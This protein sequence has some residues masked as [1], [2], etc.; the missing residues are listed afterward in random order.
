MERSAAH[1]FA[2]LVA[3]AASSSAHVTL[4]PNFGAAAGSYFFTS[5]KVPHGT[6]DLET[7]KLTVHIPHGLSTAVPEAKP[8]WVATTTLRSI[9]PYVSHGAT[10]DTAPATI[11][12]TA[13]CEGD[14]A[15][16]TCDNADHAGLHN[17]HLLEFSIQTKLG[18]DFG[19][20]QITGEATDDATIW[21]GEHALWFR[22]EQFLSTPGTN[23]GNIDSKGDML[24]W[25]G[26][27][28]GDSSWAAAQPKP[29]PFLFIYSSDSCVATDSTGESSQV[30]M[31]WG[32]SQAVV[33]PA[34]HQEEV[35]TKAQVLSWIDES[36]LNLYELIEAQGAVSTQET[37]EHDDHDD[38]NSASVQMATSLS[39]VALA[40]GCVLLG[41]FVALTT[42]RLKRPR[43]FKRALLPDYD[44]EKPAS[45][46][47]Q[48]PPSVSVSGT[49]DAIA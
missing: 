8:G 20:D 40:I 41:I 46:M 1:S 21:Q 6:A 45:P 29:S 12:W 34:L 27:V 48:S 11:T 17:S 42:W 44:E 14:G 28:E 9:E 15:P 35:Q 24:S 33:E 3:L 25:T 23:D 47:H 13:V 30:G 7:T 22:T 2:L 4:N 32:S 19:F 16:T 38:K 39:V 49:P 36:E 10:V 18:C 43:A 5:V 31:R 26:A 37:S